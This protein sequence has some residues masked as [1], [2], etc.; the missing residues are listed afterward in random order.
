MFEIAGWIGSFFL[1]VCSVPQA[2]KS[3]RQGHSRGLS[4]IMLWLW[5]FGMMFSLAYFLNL[6]AWPA[7]MNYTFNLFVCGVIILYYHFPRKG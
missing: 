3:W 2:L 1:L 6:K 4:P 7:V 5:L